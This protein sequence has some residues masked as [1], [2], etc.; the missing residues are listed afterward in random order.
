MDEE[1]WLRRLLEACH[2]TLDDLRGRE[3]YRARDLV[4]EREQMCRLERNFNH[5]ANPRPPEP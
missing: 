4:S 3:V 2:R 5:L 1:A